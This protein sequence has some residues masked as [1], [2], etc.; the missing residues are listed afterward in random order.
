MEDKFYVYAYLRGKGS[1]VANIR[2]PYYIGKGCSNRATAPHHRK[3]APPKERILYIK[4]NLTEEEAFALEIALISYYGRK[5]LGTGILI[6]KTDGGE[7][8]SNPSNST[9]QKLS[10][11]K[12]NESAETR[13]KR[14][15]AAK[16]RKRTP[17]T[18]ETK[19][20]IAESKFGSTHTES[21]KEK[22]SVAASGRKH[23]AMSREKISEKLANK[24]KPKVT[25]PHCSVTGGISAMTRWHFQQCKLNQENQN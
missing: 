23:S 14:S 25:C 20:K 16:N 18:S 8:I 12:R 6:N 2:S 13:K 5:D 11:A 17:L 9:R 22:M 10:A 19:A 1:T 24:P 4:T 7:G 15:I 21:T 3:S